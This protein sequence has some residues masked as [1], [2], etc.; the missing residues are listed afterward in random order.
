MPDQSSEKLISEN[1]KKRKDK[2]IRESYVK[3]MNDERKYKKAKK[4]EAYKP[5][6]VRN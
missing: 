6:M 4:R 2:S 5:K 3:S 1:Y